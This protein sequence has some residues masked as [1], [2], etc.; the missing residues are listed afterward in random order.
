MQHAMNADI[1]RM[2]AQAGPNWQATRDPGSG[3]TYWFDPATGATTWNDPYRGGPGGAPGGGPPR[4]KGYL[5]PQEKTAFWQA[6]NEVGFKGISDGR[7][8][9][10]IP[11][12]YEPIAHAFIQIDRGN[13]NVMDL[14]EVNRLMSEIGMFEGEGKT[15]YDMRKMD[16]DGHGTVQLHEFV[17]E[18][19]RRACEMQRKKSGGGGYGHGY[20]DHKHKKDKKDKKGKD[21]K[22]KHKHSGY[23][24]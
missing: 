14:D 7:Q 8:L 16:M 18:M 20:D 6:F 5:T 10:Q 19:C 1:N 2:K 24:Y 9:Q 22:D 21:K 13:D 17:Q 4:A 23:G 11:P 12:L 3:R 15:A